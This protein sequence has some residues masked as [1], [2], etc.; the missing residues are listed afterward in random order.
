VSDVQMA[1]NLVRVV[2]MVIL[3]Y[4][5]LLGTE[6]KDELTKKNIEKIYLWAFAWS[7]G[8]TVNGVDLFEKAMAEIFPV[9]QLPRG[10]AFNYLITITK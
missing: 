10:S 6:L 3:Y 5:K 9:D 8:A 1:V 2:R 7:V 4:N